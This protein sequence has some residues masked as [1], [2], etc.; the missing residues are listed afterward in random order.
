MRTPVLNEEIKR[1][2]ILPRGNVLPREKTGFKVIHSEEMF[3]NYV[4]S[5]RNS[6]EAAIVKESNFAVLKYISSH[7]DLLKINKI[8]LTS[9]HALY[10]KNVFKNVKAV[11]KINNIRAIVD[12]KK[13]NHTRY[14]SKYFESINSLLPH[15][16]I[17]FGCVESNRE[18]NKRLYHN[19]NKVLAGLIISA[20]YLFHR[21]LPR[22]SFFKKMYFALTKGKYRFLSTAETLGRLVSC[23]FEIIEYKEIRNL[24]YFIGMKAGEPHYDIP[25]NYGP[26]FRQKRTNRKGKTGYRYKIRTHHAYSEF[27]E[28]YVLNLNGSVSRASSKD[29]RLNILGRVLRGNWF[30][31]GIQ[32]LHLI[33]EKVK[34]IYSEG[35]IPVKIFPNLSLDY[36]F[37]IKNSLGKGGKHI[38]MNIGANSR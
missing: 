19:K 12:F 37:Y 6:F 16:G 11:T 30:K 26:F 3:K 21:V 28:D 20:E 27:L 4:P 9:T 23:G 34:N 5:K 13:V 22:I 31:L 25:P 1:S 24:T 29:I 32:S 7:L 35:F 15:A 8:L 17:Y 38:L 36:F 18:R 14:V 10:S 2:K 33:V